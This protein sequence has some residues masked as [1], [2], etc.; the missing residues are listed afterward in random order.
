MAEPQAFKFTYQE[1]AA[2][3]V[4]ELGLSEGLWGVYLKFGIAAGNV[5]SGPEDLRPTAIVPV[6]EVGLQRFSEPS[7]LTVDAAEP[8]GSTSRKGKARAGVADGAS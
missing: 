7:N 3:M 1:L 6:L 8:R 5:G 4:R 2:L